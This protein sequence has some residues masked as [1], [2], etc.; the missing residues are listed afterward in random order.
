MFLGAG[1]STSQGTSGGH[2]LGSLRYGT[3]TQVKEIMA[4]GFKREDVVRELEGAKGDKN[5]AIGA[6]FAKSFSVPK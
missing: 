5:L 2:V 6:L 1:P 4:L 3:E